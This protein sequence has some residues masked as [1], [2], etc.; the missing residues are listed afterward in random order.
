MGA[1]LPVAVMLIP[2]LYYYFRQNASAI[3]RR[4][5]RG[6]KIYLPFIF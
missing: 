2:A 3:F 6:K 1:L 4:G 5:A